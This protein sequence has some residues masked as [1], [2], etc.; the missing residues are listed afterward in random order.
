M[1]F[2]IGQSCRAV[3]WWRAWRRSVGV[4]R[5]RM[6]RCAALIWP[7]L[8]AVL[9][10]TDSAKVSDS[11]LVPIDVVTVQFQFASQARFPQAFR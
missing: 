4:E 9:I 11:A 8:I 1:V 10:D 3:V 6:R 2:V 5:R 7:E